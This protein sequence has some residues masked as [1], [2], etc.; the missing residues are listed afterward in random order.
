MRWCQMK[1]EKPP[2]SA[3]KPADAKSMVAIVTLC[4]AIMIGGGLVARAVKPP[5]ASASTEQAAPGETGVFAEA[6]R[7]TVSEVGR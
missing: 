4:A 2:K 3:R 5:D 1:K 6:E 7:A